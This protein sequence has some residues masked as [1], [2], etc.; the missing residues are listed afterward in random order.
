MNAAIAIKKPPV[1]R[2]IR[3]QLTTSIITMLLA[4]YWN[5]TT[6][7][8]AGMGGLVVVAGNSYFCWR[9]FHHNEALEA[10]KIL[11]SFYIAGIGKFIIMA[12]L[13]ALVFRFMT[14]LNT[15]ALLLGFVLN[16]LVGTF[17]AAIVL[18]S[19]KT[20]LDSKQR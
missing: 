13:L 3:F 15:I 5:V 12:I 4:S 20:Q 14:P 1:Y 18:Q 17:G 2:L 16:L 6:G 8:S 11:R 10:A 7:I 19:D 9:A